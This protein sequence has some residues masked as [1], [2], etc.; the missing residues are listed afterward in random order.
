MEKA[1]VIPCKMVWVLQG[2]QQEGFR[3]PMQLWYGYLQ[4]KQHEGFR[5]PEQSRMRVW[6]GYSTNET[7]LQIPT[8]SHLRNWVR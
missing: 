5:Y 1:L 3:Y 7:G 8:G 2:K 4:G 6:Y